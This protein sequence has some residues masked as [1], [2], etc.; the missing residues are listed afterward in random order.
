MKDFEDEVPGYKWNR[1][2]VEGLCSLSLSPKTEDTFDNLRI[3]YQFM[4][5]M[6]YVGIKEEEL[7]EAW[8]LD[9]DQVK[10]ANTSL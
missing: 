10:S 1:K 9:M 4:I 3:C 2:I 7:L 8:I 5:K 6:G